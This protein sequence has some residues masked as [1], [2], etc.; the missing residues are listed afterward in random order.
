MDY[1][2]NN[3]HTISLN[4]PTGKKHDFFLDKTGNNGIGEINNG[5]FFKE[6]E[7]NLN[8][9]SNPDTIVS[10]LPMEEIPLREGD[11][12]NVV[13]LS[14][15]EVSPDDYADYI[16]EIAES[17]IHST[18]EGIPYSRNGQGNPKHK[19]QKAMD[20]ITFGTEYVA[21][22]LGVSS[23]AIRNYV[24]DYN[25]FLKIEKNATGKRLF[26]QDQIDML[27]N[28]MR[29][30][31]ERGYTTARMKAYLQDPENEKKI[32]SPEERMEEMF[33]KLQ[34]AMQQTMMENMKAFAGELMENNIKLLEMKDTINTQIVD[35]LKGQVVDQGKAI[36]EL[37]DIVKSQAGDEKKQE[38]SMRIIEELKESIKQKDKNLEELT[39]TIKKQQEDYE[40]LQKTTRKKIFGLF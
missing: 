33:G 21:K 24:E 19:N 25:E 18:I 32:A 37:L 39:Q 8:M 31:D 12:E 15:E 28:I 40:Y 35:E 34:L 4:N 38:E 7:D 27:E 29:I 36:S 23:Q 17:E 1:S 20:E 11:D 5:S 14:D 9:K 13:H 6:T 3:T 10:E 2:Y 26:R 16:E 30:K 22:V